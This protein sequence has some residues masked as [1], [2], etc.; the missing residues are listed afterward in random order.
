MLREIS[1]IDLENHENNNFA[2]AN[3]ENN[4]EFSQ[5]YKKFDLFSAADKKLFTNIIMS[6]IF[7][8]FNI[9]QPKPSKAF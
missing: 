5:L 9:I 7:E 3:I 6:T 1:G 2:S 4:L 8:Q